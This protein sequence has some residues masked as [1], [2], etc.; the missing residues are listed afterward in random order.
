MGPSAWWTERHQIRK[1]NGTIIMYIYIYISCMIIYIYTYTWLIKNIQFAR[2]AC[3]SNLALLAVIS[4]GDSAGV[5]Y[6]SKTKNMD[7][8]YEI[9]KVPSVNN[10]IHDFDIQPYARWSKSVSR[11]QSRTEQRYHVDSPH[12]IIAAE[13]KRDPGLREHLSKS[14]D[15]FLKV[16]VSQCRSRL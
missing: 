11:P 6:L 8:S 2:L 9:K 4:L 10:I 16:P 15:I 3:S 5:C 13:T 1:N 12:K 14:F 7:D